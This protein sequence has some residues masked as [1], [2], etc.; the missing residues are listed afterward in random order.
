[1]LLGLEDI[2]LGK[3]PALHQ[4]KRITAADKANY[5]IW[6]AEQL[7]QY[8]YSSEG[9]HTQPLIHDHKLTQHHHHRFNNASPFT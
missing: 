6:S 7:L 1:M 8:P 9:L 4:H 2:G 3:D 5:G